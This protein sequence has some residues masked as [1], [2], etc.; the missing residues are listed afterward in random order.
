MTASFRFEYT[1]AKVPNPARLQAIGRDWGRDFL[2][3][4]QKE[5]LSGRTGDM[6]LVRRSGNLARDWNTTTDVSGASLAVNIKTHGT[7]DKYAG[8]QE[9]GGTVKPVSAQWLWIPLSENKTSAG[10]AR[11]TPTQAMSNGGFLTNAKTG[12]KI[13]WAY[14]LTAASRK[15]ASREVKKGRAKDELVPLFVLKKEVTIPARLGATSLFESM[16]PLLGY[17]VIAEVEGAWDA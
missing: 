9:F 1:T 7:A 11:I 15:R 13:F 14:G 16:L 2:A 3:R 17:A 8:L 12:G 5:R 10:V 6:G 4:L